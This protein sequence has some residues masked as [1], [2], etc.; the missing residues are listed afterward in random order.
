MDG[1]AANQ[2]ALPLPALPIWHVAHTLRK[3]TGS[4]QGKLAGCSK[5]PEEKHVL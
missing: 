5:S 2:R 3:L 1:I 4:H